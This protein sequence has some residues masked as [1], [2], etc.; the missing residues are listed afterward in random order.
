MKTQAI[1]TLISTLHTTSSLPVLFSLPHWHSV[2]VRLLLLFHV[3]ENYAEDKESSHHGEDTG[4]V[5]V[6]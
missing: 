3:E 4:I 5:W 2:L 6:G 1:T